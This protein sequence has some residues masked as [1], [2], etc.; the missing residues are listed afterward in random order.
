MKFINLSNPYALDNK[1]YQTIKSNTPSAEVTIMFAQCL[2][3][4]SQP[5][6][7][8]LQQTL[9]LSIY[10]WNE[11]DREV[12]NLAGRHHDTLSLACLHT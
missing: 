2:T 1:F 12:H 3:T 5:Q 4:V 9:A 7:Y 11:V 8:L 6:D 10:T